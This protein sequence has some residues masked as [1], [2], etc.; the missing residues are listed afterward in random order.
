[1]NSVQGD[2]VLTV[3]SFL[4]WQVDDKPDEKCTYCVITYLLRIKPGA[5]KGGACL[6]VWSGS[7]PVFMV[8]SGMRVRHVVKAPNS[9]GNNFGKFGVLG[10]H[11]MWVVQFMCLSFAVVFINIG[12]CDC[13]CSCAYECL[14]L[15]A[16][17][18]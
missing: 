12:W 4:F 3:F 15:H 16:F 1:M 5:E 10:H 7:P 2:T 8:M 11:D 13:E 14:P 9:I 18:N 6:P 17:H